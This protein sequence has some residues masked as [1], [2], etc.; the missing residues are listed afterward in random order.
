MTWEEVTVPV[1]RGGELV[2]SR[3]RFTVG[4]SCVVEVSVGDDVHARGKGPALFG[5]LVSARRELETHDVLVAC[6][7]ARRDV[8]PSAMLRQAT[9]GRRAYVLTVPRTAARPPTVDIL[10]SGSR[11]VSAGDGG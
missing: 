8:C 2:T 7:G 10:C 5:A 4:D 3:V 11:Q 1:V 9:G 6:N